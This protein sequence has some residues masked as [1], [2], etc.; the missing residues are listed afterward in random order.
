MTEFRF[1][2]DFCESRQIYDSSELM[3]RISP[4]FKWMK[5]CRKVMMY[6]HYTQ[7]FVKK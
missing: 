7:I 4:K 6:L 2:T 1:R 5:L 3:Q